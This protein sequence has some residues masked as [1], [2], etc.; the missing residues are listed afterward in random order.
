MTT[1]KKEKKKRRRKRKKKM[2][3]KKKKKKKKKRKRKW[4]KACKNKDESTIFCNEKTMK[5]VGDTSSDRRYS[6]TIPNI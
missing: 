4:E 3:K 1:T 5:S 6:T 2:K